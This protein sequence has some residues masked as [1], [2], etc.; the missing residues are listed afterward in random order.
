MQYFEF[1]QNRWLGTRFLALYGDKAGGLEI[2]VEAI[3]KI[4]LSGIV[5]SSEQ[6]QIRCFVDE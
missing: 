4:K 2:R 5:F 1:R 6:S 3:V